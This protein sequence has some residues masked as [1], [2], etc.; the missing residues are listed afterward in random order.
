MSEP[1]FHTS[2]PSCGAPVS[3]HSATA[4]TVVCGYC[5]SLLVRRDQS[6]ADSGRDSALIEDF[7]PLQIGS[8]GRFDEQGFAVIGRLQARY[9]AGMWNEWYLSFD[10]GGNGWLSEAGDLYV[11]TRRIDGTPPLPAFDGIRAG[12][13]VFAH[14]GKTFVAADVREIT[15]ERTAAQGELPFE[16]PEKMTGRVADWR[17]ENLFLTT[18]YA[19]PQAPELFAGRTVTLGQLALQHTRSD[20]QIRTSAGR[21]RGERVS[22]TCPNCGGTLAWP[23]GVVQHLLCPSCGSDL[24]VSEGKAELIAADNRRKA[25]H[26]MLTLPLG[27]E[28]SHHGQRYTII[29]AVH[30]DEL[31]PEDTLR[32]LQG[33][34]GFGAVPEGWW[35]EYLLFSPQAGFLWLVETPDGKWRISETLADWP[36]LDQNAEPQGLGK[37]Y[38]YGGRVNY[39]AGAFYWHIRH[40]DLNL[41]TDYRQGRNTLCAERS[42]QEL[43]WSKSSPIAANTVY[44]MFGIA[45][46]PQPGRGI[47]GSEP[48]PKS[49]IYTLMAVFCIFNLPA[50]L[51]MPGDDFLWSAV[52]SGV[53]LYYIHHWGSK[54]SKNS[55]NNKN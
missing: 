32:Y 53:V 12:E 21:L 26:Q 16:L 51:M 38:D 52:V 30:K 23:A 17:C 7:S 8:A 18:D 14:G 46:T 25:Q 48:I 37:L 34:H 2:C 42:P 11:L 28:G 49:L 4:V 40:G 35:V 6:L 55:K 9:D 5:N 27:A 33:Q 3:V 19:D 20:D 15:L 24:A 47:M 44:R 43:A 39:A 29:G 50:W 10:D 13:S 31:P 41:Y 45:R 1:L 54:D 36:R 22:E